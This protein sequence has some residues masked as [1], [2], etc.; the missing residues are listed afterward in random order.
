MRALFRRFLISGLLMFVG[1]LEDCFKATDC[2]IRGD[3]V[4]VA[5]EQRLGP[6]AA[7]G[8]VSI[9]LKFFRF[10][11]FTTD[12]AGECNANA[13]CKLPS[14]EEENERSEVKKNSSSRGN[15]QIACRALRGKSSNLACVF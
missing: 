13:V 4:V 10:L 2:F 8:C 1:R 12:A 14:G 7:G 15:D 6:P 5:C 9:R 11:L 3:S